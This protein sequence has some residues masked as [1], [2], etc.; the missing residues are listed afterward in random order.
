MATPCCRLPPWWRV[1]LGGRPGHVIDVTA[2]TSRWVGLRVRWPSFPP[3][4]LAA[5]DRDAFRKVIACG[6]GPT[7]LD[8][9]RRFVERQT[10]PGKPRCAR[11]PAGPV[12]D[13]SKPP[14]GHVRDA[15]G[16]RRAGARWRSQG[17][18]SLGDK[19]PQAEVP[20]TRTE[21]GHAAVKPCQRQYPA[22]GLGLGVVLG[23][24][25]AAPST[26]ARHPP[27]GQ[28]CSPPPGHPH[29]NQV[30]LAAP[31]RKYQLRSSTI[32]RDRPL[33]HHPAWSRQDRPL[34]AGQTA[35]IA[36]EAG[37]RLTVAG[38]VPFRSVLQDR[39]RPPVELRAARSGAGGVQ[40]P[41]FI[42][43]PPAL[44]AIEHGRT[45]LQLLI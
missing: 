3:A 22:V 14:C 27:T 2:A 8:V 35:C 13:R 5:V 17:G 30:G 24:P 4:E 41:A 37:G 43:F 23:V 21:Q 25:A 39:L 9:P 26:S 34:I 36:D 20:P 12:D 1:D 38:P 11:S 16:G 33:R 15:A 7:D 28:N 45:R 19:A 10:E 40:V 42:E 32:E 6:G 18:V 29:R 31:R 44:V